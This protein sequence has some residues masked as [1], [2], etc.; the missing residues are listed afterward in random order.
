[1][2]IDPLGMPN[3]P[4]NRGALTR[5]LE[6]GESYAIVS[7]EDNGRFVC[8]FCVV[9]VRHLGGVRYQGTRVHFEP[10]T[11]REGLDVVL[12]LAEI[13][14]P[15]R[16]LVDTSVGGQMLVDLLRACAEERATQALT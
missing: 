9:M 16:L 14:R 3:T 10:H 13:H 15:D 2:K 4:T 7:V 1:M 5:G 8:G 12:G 11:V 6:P